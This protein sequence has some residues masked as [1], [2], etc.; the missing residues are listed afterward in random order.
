MLEQGKSV[1]SPLSEREAAAETKCDQLTAA[2]IPQPP[3]TAWA[4][5]VEKNRSKVEQ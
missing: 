3:C 1:R 2:P 4:K 5:E